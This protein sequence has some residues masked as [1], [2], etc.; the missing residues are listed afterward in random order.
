M[1]R[2]RTTGGSPW[3]VLVLLAA[4]VAAGVGGALW[5]AF[6]ADLA[7]DPDAG[8]GADPGAADHAGDV[9]DPSNGAAKAGHAGRREKAA[10]A[11][12]PAGSG[13]IRGQVRLFRTREPVAGFALTLSL[14]EP[15]PGETRPAGA[16]TLGATT[17]AAGNFVLSPVPARGGW[18]LRGT[19][20]GFA[21]VEVTGIDL[22]A[23]QALDV[24]VLWL[25]VPVDLP[26][27]VVDTTGAPIEGAE[28]SAFTL[29]RT[30]PEEENEWSAE[31]RE[32]RTLALA[33]TPRPSRAARTDAKGEVVLRG[34]MPGAYRAVASASGFAAR[35]RTNLMLVPDAPA[36]PVRFV[37]GPGHLLEG[38]VTDEKDAPVAD[39]KVI[40]ALKQGW[41]PSLDKGAGS[42]AA[43]GA[44]RIEGLGAGPYFVYVLREGRPLLQVGEV[45]IPETARFDIRLRPGGTIR[46]TVTDDATQKP[47]ADA[48]IHMSMQNTWTPLATR[49][50]K[51]GTFEIRD[52]PAGPLG[53][54]NIRAE[55]YVPFPDPSARRQGQGESLR[56]GQ[57]MV[58][59]VALR[60]GLSQEF[61]VIGEGKGPL[62]GAE[63][64]L[65]LATM[66]SGAVRPW[67]GTTDARGRAEL[68]GLL[69]GEYLAVVVAD[70]WVQQG[71]PPGWKDALG[72]PMAFPAA[73]RVTVGAGPAGGAPREL[74]LTRGTFVAGKVV[75]A[76]GKPAPGAQVK[77]EGVHREF[78][79]FTDAEG[80]FRVDAVPPLRRTFVAA[81]TSGGATGQSEP[82]AVRDGQPAERIEVRLADPGRITGHVQTSTGA[83][84]VGAV[85]RFLRGEQTLENQWAWRRI[86]DAARHP[87][88][89]DGGYEI[90]DVPAGDVTVRV[91]AEGALPA[92]RAA[93]VTAGFETGGIDLVLAAPVE[94]R[95]RVQTQQGAGVAGASVRCDFQ[96]RLSGDGGYAPSF[97]AFPVATTDAEGRFALRGLVEG[98]YSVTARAPGFS[99]A[100]HVQT[101]T[102][103]G[104]VLLTLATG[105]PVAGIVKD[106]GGQPLGG[107]PVRAEPVGQV[108]GGWWWGQTAYSAPDG[109]FE[110]QDLAEG[111]YRLKVSGS[112]QWG[113]EVNVEDTVKEGVAPGDRNVE[114]VVRPG[115]TI[116]GRLVDREK[117]PVRVGWIFANYRSQNPNEQSWES[118]RW[119]QVRADGTF[120][121]AG[122][123]PGVYDVGAYG[124]FQQ[125]S[126]KG[127]QA[128]RA[129]LVLQVEA[130]WVIS[131]V[132]LDEKALSV[133][134][135]DV[136]IRK[137]GAKE[138]DWCDYAEPGDGQF[139]ITGLDEARYDVQVTVEG[140]A[141]GVVR[142]VQAGRTDLEVRVGKGLDIGGSVVDAGGR[143]VA[144]AWVN[145]ES[146]PGTDGAAPVDTG[147][148]AGADGRFKVSG[149]LAG[150]YRI[151]AR[152]D[153]FAPVLLAGVAAGRDDLRLVMTTGTSVKGVVVDGDGVPIPNVQVQLSTTEGQTWIA[154]AQSDAEGR[155]EV[156][157]VPEEGKW[158]VRLQRHDSG[159]WSSKKLETPV[160]SGATDV[161]LEWK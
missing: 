40:A 120:R 145:V 152:S 20:E 2:T 13:S 4:L 150:A 149:L 144:G 26:A 111:V 140:L 101:S 10:V 160:E 61:T 114:I 9:A 37:L 117:A 97:S 57:T 132:V 143:G 112:W 93:K 154:G 80:A 52:I 7:T 8:G 102:S 122:L 105:K 43:D 58:R 139:V 94:I 49:T 134:G 81:T 27:V 73:W 69:P 44:Y 38:K 151:V 53:Y 23:D 89:K 99:G 72:S 51:D 21:P 138:W 104:E 130:A 17:D 147:A 113:R 121:L 48:E 79:V 124:N 35:S 50:G 148:E 3:R 31:L 24:G 12:L 56:E 103:A 116:E 54:F 65:H 16:T 41:L 159:R 14:P 146:V 67:S 127:V 42:T 141:P 100:A 77:V 63:V 125:K 158:T 39:A 34:L 90:P 11:A 123:K 135:F 133:S 98:T 62:E 33:S 118:Q 108:Q 87:V 157:R 85:V 29:G 28:V 126:E 6:D 161:R 137:E 82:F 30:L 59:D 95:G 88:G 92:V 86:D 64:R 91:D 46:G 25:A 109:T 96:G 131:G 142:N 119:S 71:L 128:G 76:S 115:M 136:M 83:A 156:L 129:D 84:P 18:E 32:Q 1:G 74:R 19:R 60:R 55:G 36:A 75:L 5:I 68:T 22:A 45:V 107:I 106:P 110:I 70:G 15:A 78:P 153:G 66:W 155:F 47:I